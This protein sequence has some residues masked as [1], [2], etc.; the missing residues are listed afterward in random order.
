MQIFYAIV[1]DF[2]CVLI[3]KIFYLSSGTS[4]CLTLQLSSSSYHKTNNYSNLRLKTPTEKVDEYFL[5]NFADQ[6]SSNRLNFKLK[7][8]VK[9]KFLGF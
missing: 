1:C 4:T 6:S 2:C 9:L 7:S 8:Y 3:E 5:R